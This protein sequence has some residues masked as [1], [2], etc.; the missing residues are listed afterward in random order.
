MQFVS[1]QCDAA[2]PGRPDGSIGLHGA[3]FL[4][5]SWEAPPPALADP[6]SA[7]PAFGPTEGLDQPADPATVE[8]GRLDRLWTPIG[9]FHLL[10]RKDYDTF[11][12]WP[13]MRDLLLGLA[14]GG[15]L[16]NTSL[17]QDFR[18]W[19]QDRVC[20]TDL[21]Q[22]GRFWKTFGEAAIFAPSYAGL[23]VL[24]TMYD[25]Y[26]LG[27][28]LGEF[29]ARATRS[30][31][32]GAPPMLL[33]Q[34]LLGGDRP[35]SDSDNSRWRPFE[36]SHGIS[37]HAFVG[38][39]PFITAAQMADGPWLKGAF[40]CLSVLPGWSRV[41]SDKHYLSQA[42]LGWWF[43]Y[44]ACRAVDRPI[45]PERSYSVVPL[46]APDAVGASLTYRM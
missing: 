46:M 3:D 19:Y 7:P 42:V 17:D 20:T 26:P 45:Q 44:L 15:A 9:Q 31:L 37:G 13:G 21:D 27:G 38:A 4:R 43:A 34:A 8:Q 6:L 33:G 18:D 12:S 5:S 30:Y 14:V 35:A 2:E 29:G 16:A 23:A 36:A 32:V 28:L 39:V 25:D 24:G 40:Y 22:F 11:Y 41:E 1:G 10:I